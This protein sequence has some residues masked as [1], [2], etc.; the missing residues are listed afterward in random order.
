MSKNDDALARAVAEAERFLATAKRYEA[1]KAP[2]S[3][4]PARY[5]PAAKAHRHDAVGSCP[6]RAAVVRA[7][8]DATRALATL[9][10]ERGLW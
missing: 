1:C 5:G 3:E 6:E 4:P 2:K 9:R 8:M 10:R 7:S